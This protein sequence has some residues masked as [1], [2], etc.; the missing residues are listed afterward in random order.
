[1]PA[2]AGRPVNLEVPTRLCDRRRDFAI[3]SPARHTD[4]NFVWLAAHLRRL[5]MESVDPQEVDS[6]VVDRARIE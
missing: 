2:A 1:M 6:K 4:V 3:T 5:S